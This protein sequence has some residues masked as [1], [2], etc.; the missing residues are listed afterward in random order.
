MSDI[1]TKTIGL[2]V[3]LALTV[4]LLIN[5]VVD[6]VLKLTGRK[7]ISQRVWQEPLIGIPVMTPVVGMGI[8]LAVHL[9]CR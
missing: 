2:V 4:Q 5:L 3:F 6:L 7:T 1:D 8:S 9:F